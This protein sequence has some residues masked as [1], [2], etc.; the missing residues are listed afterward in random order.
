M[1]EGR[2]NRDQLQAPL[3]VLHP[4]LSGAGDFMAPVLPASSLNC[5]WEREGKQ[6]TRKNKV[7][8]WLAK[9]T[10]LLQEILG[11]WSPKEVRVNSKH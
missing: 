8:T 1:R 5:Y 9:H 6:V 7:R 11:A 10:G 3:T 4:E 2:E